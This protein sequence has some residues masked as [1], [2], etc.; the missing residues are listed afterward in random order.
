MS[1]VSIC[2]EYLSVGE[3]HLGPDTG[4]ILSSLGIGKQVEEASEQHIG[5]WSWPRPGLFINLT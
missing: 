4:F 3:S 5:I 2:L 1:V